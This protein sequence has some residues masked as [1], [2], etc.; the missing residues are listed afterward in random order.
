[1][2]PAEQSACGVRIG[3][4]T[5]APIVDHDTARRR[6]LARYAVVKRAAA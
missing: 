4:E 2:S 3:K 5:P 6:T 1:M